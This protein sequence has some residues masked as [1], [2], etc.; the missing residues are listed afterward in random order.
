MLEAIKDLYDKRIV[1]DGNFYFTFDT[2]LG[3][4]GGKR[5][6]KKKSVAKLI[7]LRKVSVTFA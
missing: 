4:Y 5:T 2:S 1:L 6:L 7:E 3:S